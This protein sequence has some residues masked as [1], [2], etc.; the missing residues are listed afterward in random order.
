MKAGLT[1]DGIFGPA[2]E[3]TV[4]A[5]QK[6]QGLEPDGIAGPLTREKIKKFF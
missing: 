6:K 2:T 1:A 4:K 3:K 5:F